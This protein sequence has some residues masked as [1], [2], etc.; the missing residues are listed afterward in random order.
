M[1]NDGTLT[2]LISSTTEYNS[3]HKEYRKGKT[4]HNDKWDD[5]NLVIKFGFKINVKTL[6]K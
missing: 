1:E 4:K 6:S 2:M 5:N 3:G